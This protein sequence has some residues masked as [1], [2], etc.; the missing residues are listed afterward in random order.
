MASKE[1]QGYY[2][3]F[4]TLSSSPI[5]SISSTSVEPVPPFIGSHF[6]ALSMDKIEVRL[7]YVG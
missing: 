7:E 6:T 4:R 3:Q 5:F 1:L 2:A